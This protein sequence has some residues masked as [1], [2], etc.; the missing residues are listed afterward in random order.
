MELASGLK[1]LFPRKQNFWPRI[2]LNNNVLNIVYPI[3]QMSTHEPKAVA[4]VHG[5]DTVAA[6]RHHTHPVVDRTAA[7]M[8]M[9]PHPT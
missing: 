3:S 5:V 1:V 2:S 4:S 6:P 9:P 8:G 7:A